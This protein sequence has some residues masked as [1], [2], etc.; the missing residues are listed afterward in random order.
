MS[1][2][3]EWSARLDKASI[4]LKRSAPAH[5]TDITTA[6]VEADIVHVGDTYW[7]GIYPF[8]DYSAALTA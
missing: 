7:N 3:S 5:T 1:S 6:F 2:V 8:I 4:A